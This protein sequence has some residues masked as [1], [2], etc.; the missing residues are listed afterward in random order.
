MNSHEIAALKR[1]AMNNTY[2]PHGDIQ[3]ADCVIGFSFGYVENEGKIKPGKSNIQ[4]AAY[5]E[6]YLPGVPLIVQFEIS[7]ALRECK[8]DLVIRESR[9]KG[10]Y[11]HSREIA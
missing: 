5:I 1:H 8:A 10:E 3:E 11:L 4:L 2:T 7:D 6:R 9:H